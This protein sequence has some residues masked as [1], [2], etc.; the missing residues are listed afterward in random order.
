MRSEKSYYSSCYS[1]CLLDSFF[2][3]FRL[4]ANRNAGSTVLFEYEIILQ[5][6]RKEEEEEERE[7][8][9]GGRRSV[10]MISTANFCAWFDSWT[11]WLSRLQVPVF[12]R[13][14]DRVRAGWIRLLHLRWSEHR[15]VSTQPP[16]P[17]TLLPPVCD[18]TNHDDHVHVWFSDRYT[19]NRE[20]TTWDGPSQRLVLPGLWQIKPRWSRARLVL[21]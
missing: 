6:K 14:E 16:A 8:V 11:L 5:C 18:R 2:C 12:G 1:S 7:L 3:P 21:V 4:T 19:G 20:L 10:L 13:T 17:C 9:G 15:S